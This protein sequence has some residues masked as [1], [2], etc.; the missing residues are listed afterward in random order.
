[1]SDHNTN[2][3]LKVLH[4]G[5]INRGQWPLQ[6]CTASTGFIPAALCD[7]N[8]TAL[9]AARTMTGL[10]AAA[11]FTDLDQA[12][13]ESRVDCAI[14][15]APTIY[16]VPIA[17]KMMEAKIP[18]LIEKGMA[19]D[20]AS[21]LRL[22]NAVRENAAIVAIAQNYRYR[23]LEKTI[24]HAIHQP[25][26]PAYLGKVHQLSYTEQRVRPHPR[27]LNY[28]FASIWDMSCHH[29]DNLQY[30]FGPVE[31]VTAF[32]W[33]ADWSA[34]AHDNNTS[35]HIRHHCGT[36][37]HYLHT[38]DAARSTLEIEAHGEKGAL[39]YRDDKLMF[40]ERP[41]EQFGSRPIIPILLL[42]SD[43]EGDVL[44]DFH[45]YIV[46]EEEPGISARHNLQTMTMCELMVRSITEKRTINR[47]EIKDLS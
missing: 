31:E 11:C 14:V 16:H 13:R 15:C 41:L 30:W 27:T 23:S 2:S 32:S 8:A 38:H 26:S 45:R 34:Y 46:Q 35:A 28:P 24:W 18:V 5:V 3:L 22:T 7:V 37:V 25:D 4:V 29:L 39:I 6:Y 20:W 9:D 33:K 44:R 10:P 12:I 47:N 1:M 17:L 19:P 43:N 21:A 42:E 36:N 40:N